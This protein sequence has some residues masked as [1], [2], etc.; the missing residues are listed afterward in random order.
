MTLCAHFLLLQGFWDPLKIPE[1]CEETHLNPYEFIYARYEFD[2]DTQ[3]TSAD[4]IHLY[5]KWPRLALSDEEIRRLGTL[6]I[7]YAEGGVTRR[8]DPVDA[9]SPLFATSPLG[10]SVDGSATYELASLVGG[11]NPMN[12]RATSVNGDAEEGGQEAEREISKIEE[13]RIF[14][15]VDRM[16]LITM[17][18]TSKGPGGCGLD[19]GKLLKHR[20]ILAYMP[21]HDM[22]E[23]RALEAEWLTFFDMPWNQPTDQIKD[24]FGEKIGLYFKWLGLYTSWL[25]IAALLGFGFWINVAVDGK[26]LFSIARFSLHSLY[27]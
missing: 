2:S 3:R 8:I 21:L 13:A 25:T 27:N 4:M 6:G 10:A 11:T 18:I 24:Y 7:E 12:S 20:A 5:K 26:K 17:I 15:G 19:I 14:R 16:K 23:L 22:V 9:T 1:V